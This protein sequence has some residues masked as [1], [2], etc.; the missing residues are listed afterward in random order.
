MSIPQPL[1]I[2]IRF[3]DIDIMGHVNN[4]VYLSY[5][6]MTRVHYFGQLLGSKWDYQ[7]DG[8]LLARNEVD[9]L[10]PIYL[11]DQPT[12]E[13]KTEKIGNKSF[14]LSY[15]IWV[16]NEVCTQGQS[17]MVGFDSTINKSIPIPDKM[18]KA[19][20]LLKTE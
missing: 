1:Q 11:T 5:F 20:E 8:F 7:K 4:S 18:R 13:M 9:Y 10:R 2:Q 17:V 14:V 6:E 15:K 16:D 19:L 3:A 12:I